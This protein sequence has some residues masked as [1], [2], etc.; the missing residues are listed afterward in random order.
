MFAMGPSFFG[1]NGTPLSLYASMNPSDCSP[2][3][4]LSNGNLRVANNNSS[5]NSGICRST[6]ALTGKV[7]FE[8]VFAVIFNPALAVIGAGV[9]TSS[10]SLSASLG[11]STADGWA[12]WGNTPGARSNGVTAVT[13]STATGDVIGFAVDVPN[14]TMWIRKNGVWIQGDPVAAA[15][16]IWTGIAGTLYAAACPWDSRVGQAVDMRFDPSTFRDAAPTGFGPLLA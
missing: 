9:A 6:K 8:A 12:M 7:Y 14:G 15:S 5:F 13:L 16:P 10:A 2:R 3:I 1:T 4:T 11:Y